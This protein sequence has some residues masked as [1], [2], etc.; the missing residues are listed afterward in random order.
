ME[1][2]Q[3]FT[4][5][6][7]DKLEKLINIKINIKNLILQ[8]EKDK[9]NYLKILK[10]KQ[11]EKEKFELL[12]K[13]VEKQRYLSLKLCNME[14]DIENTHDIGKRSRNQS[15]ILRALTHTSR[16]EGMTFL[17]NSLVF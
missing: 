5:F 11:A 3:N 6:R 15:K 14:K 17:R 1:N 2:N 10:L 4:K 9:K 12:L 16:A 8:K 7:K 13:D